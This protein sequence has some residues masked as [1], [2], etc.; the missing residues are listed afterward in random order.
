MKEGDLV[1]VKSFYRLDEDYDSFGVLID[2]QEDD[3]GFSWYQVAPFKCLSG[4]T[5]NWY[6]DYEIEIVSEM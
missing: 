1:R 6:A 2:M 5:L 4:A 3:E